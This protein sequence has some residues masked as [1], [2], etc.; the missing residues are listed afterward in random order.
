[1]AVIA[2]TTTT[3]Q[4]SQLTVREIDFIERFTR[5]W[6][7]LR[8]IMG[9]MRP[10]RKTPG[11]R[12]VSSEA[13]VT[14][15]SGT[16]AEGDEVPLSQATVVPKS[17]A[18]LS[19]KKYRKAVTAEAVAKYGAAVAVQK[20]DDALLNELQGE[21][22]EEFYDFAKTGT[23]TGQYDTFQ[24]AVSMAVSLVKDKFKKM[25]RDY[26]NIVAFVNTL[27]VGEYLG[28][29]P[30]TIQTSNGVEYLKNFLGA[31]TVIITS[32]VNQGTVLAIPA[33]NIVLYYIDPGDADFQQLGLQ[34]NTGSGETNL[35]G[36]RKEGNYGRVMGE[37]HALMGMKLW[38]EYI[39]GIANVTFGETLGSL[40]VTSTAG[41]T[42][43]TTKLTVTPAKGSGN[44][45]KYKVSNTVSAVTYGQNVQSWAAWDGTADITAENGKVITVVEC[46][47]DYKAKSTGNATVVAKG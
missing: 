11:T 44:L 18:D 39:D 9:I 43:G 35:I 25:H 32:E 26:S 12:L 47:S 28:S 46:G 6:D 31:N 3:A 4:F 7:A 34:Y 16:V 17:Y 21:V 29:A 2:N 38:A 41:T 40:T 15:Q 8:E 42:S 1:M 27:D 5:N 13:S 24:M 37:T 45:Y 30:I 33:D 19:F 23:L 36:I 10:I 14:L 22:M 20:T